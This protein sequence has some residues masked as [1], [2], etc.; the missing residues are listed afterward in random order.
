[1][2]YSDASALGWGGYSVNLN[3]VCAKGNFNEEEI[4]KSYTFR[5]LYATL[6]GLESYLDSVRGTIM[7]HR[8]DNQNVVRIL[9]YGSKKP[10]LDELALQFFKFC[11]ASSIQLHPEGIPRSEKFCTDLFSKDIDKDDY[12]LNPHLFAVADMRWGAHT[13]KRFSSFKT[14]QIPRFSSCWLNPC[15]KYLDAFSANWSGE[16]NW[17]FPPLVLYLGF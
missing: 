7:K 6:Y 14:R 5:E 17:L 8:S 2:T 16:N 9:S 15:M 13:F 12:M 3:G 1:M 4:G 10:Q 11:I